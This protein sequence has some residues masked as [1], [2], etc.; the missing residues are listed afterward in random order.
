MA[1]QND[2]V[3]TPAE[4]RSALFFT[5]GRQVPLER[6]ARDLCGD[7]HYRGRAQRGTGCFSSMEFS[8]PPDRSGVLTATAQLVDGG[9]RSG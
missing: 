6:V 3:N 4:A 1:V 8:V 5:L 7:A 9:E 2:V